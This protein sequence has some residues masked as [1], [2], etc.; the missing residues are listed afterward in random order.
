MAQGDPFPSGDKPG[1]CDD[2]WFY[3]TGDDILYSDHVWFN[4]SGQ[5]TP[6][7]RRIQ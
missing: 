4:T 7:F 3:R 5:L 2:S 1:A 6:Y